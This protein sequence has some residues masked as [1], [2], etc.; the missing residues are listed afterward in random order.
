MLSISSVMLQLR[1][2]AIMRPYPHVKHIYFL[3]K[4]DAAD[5]MRMVRDAYTHKRPL[6]RDA[7][8]TADAGERE[9]SV[10]VGGARASVRYM[11]VED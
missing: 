10:R 1:L 7:D 11:P 4:A 6:V 3:T 5:V 9:I 2:D 8:E